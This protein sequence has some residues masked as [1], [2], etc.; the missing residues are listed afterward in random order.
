MAHGRWRDCGVAA[1]WT[2]ALRTL[3]V[4]ADRWRL[5]GVGMPASQGGKDCA[6]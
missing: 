2:A 1:T 5:T 4:Q 6:W 3:S